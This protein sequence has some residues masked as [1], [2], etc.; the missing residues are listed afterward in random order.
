MDKNTLTQSK[1]QSK[2]ITAGEKSIYSM[3]KSRKDLYG[4]ILPDPNSAG[5]FVQAALTAVKMDAKLQQCTVDSLLKAISEAARYGLEPNSPLSEAALVPYGN[6]VE[7]IIEYR[8]LLKL[9]WNSGMVISIDYDKVCANDKFE[10][11]KG[12]DS[13]FVHVPL[14]GGPRGKPIA[15]Y[16]I[17]EMRGGGKVMTIMSKEEIIEHGLQHS[18]SFSSKSSPWQTNFDAMAI[19][20]VIRQMVD[21]K[22]P[23]STTA[24]AMLLAKA[25]HHEDIPEDVRHTRVEVEDAEIVENKRID[26]NWDAKDE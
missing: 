5:R 17:A 2:S 4:E 13:K 22:L 20:T 19:K 25:S 18:K 14:F 3:I 10:Y 24:E 26:S 16:S 8:G 21:K 15:Y 7:F 11:S 6:K 23:K 1:K 9:A 12:F